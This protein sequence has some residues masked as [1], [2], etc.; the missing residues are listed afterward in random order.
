MKNKT[1]SRIFIIVLVCLLLLPVLSSCALDNSDYFEYITYLEENCAQWTLSDNG[2]KLIKD[3]KVYHKTDLDCNLDPMYVYLFYNEIY[4]WESRYFASVEAPGDT[5]DSEIV[6]FY[7]SYEDGY[8]VYTTEEGA[9]KLKEFENG[10]Y[11]AAAIV[12]PDP[13]ERRSME[14]SLLE[15]IDAEFNGAASKTEKDVTELKNTER[16]DVRVYDSTKSFYKVY[17]ALYLIDGGWYYVNYDSL[18]NEYFDADGN[19]SYRRGTVELCRLS[20]DLSSEID[21]A[22]DMQRSYTVY[23]YEED[24]HITYEEFKGEDP[25]ASFGILTFWVVYAIICFALPA[26]F[27]VLGCVLARS[28]KLG[29]PKYWYLLSLIALFWIVLSLIIMII[30]LA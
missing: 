15:E 20:G 17:G 25:P 4:L 30:M 1:F 27:A 16:L 2:N 6:W 13:V 3:E 19:F 9:Q 10:N 26:A 22:A 11:S 23:T 14:L 8:I 5:S 21:S 29:K 7:D 24:E 18:G 28:E 12:S